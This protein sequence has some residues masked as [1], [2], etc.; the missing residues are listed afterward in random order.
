MDG[1]TSGGHGIARS[2]PICTALLCGSS[3]PA[4]VS[5]NINAI[6]VGILRRFLR[7]T[8]T[9]AVRIGTAAHERFLAPRF[10]VEFQSFLTGEHRE[11]Q[12]FTNTAS[13]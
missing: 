3:R 6:A 12:L 11:D 2:L 9:P 1:R 5:E 13:L 7:V 10:V 8:H 4:A